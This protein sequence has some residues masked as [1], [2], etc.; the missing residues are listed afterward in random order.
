MVLPKLL[1]QMRSGR[2]LLA[3]GCSGCADEDRCV[4]FHQGG[5]L[6]CRAD[7]SLLTHPLDAERDR[8]TRED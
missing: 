5:L 8:V 2:V 6:T 4:V 1:S 7:C 3:L